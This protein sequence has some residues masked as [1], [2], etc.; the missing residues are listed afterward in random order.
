[1]LAASWALAKRPRP[2][3]A[4]LVRVLIVAGLI[5]A[6]YVG[7]VASEWSDARAQVALVHGATGRLLGGP[8]ALIDNLLS[9][10]ERYTALLGQPGLGP[11]LFAVALPA[12]A[13]WSVAAFRHL[14][15]IGRVSCAYLLVYLGGLWIFEATKAAIYVLPAV[16]PMIVLAGGL[17]P[18]ASGSTI[19]ALTGIIM[20]VLVA[21]GMVASVHDVRALRRLRTYGDVVEVIRSSVPR[22]QRW[23]GSM[24]W[25]RGFADG[26][27]TTLPSLDWRS[28]QAGD[29]YP[30]F[31]AEWQRFDP[32]VILD[33]PEW[34]DDSR[35]LAPERAAFI[36]TVSAQCGT[37]VRTLEDEAYGPVTVVALDRNCVAAIAR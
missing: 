16:V 13:I 34:R 15:A 21:E 5:A 2:A 10:P 31:R 26:A 18:R 4:S 23:I 35:R 8:A 28:R 6:P 20:A 25:S 7:W 3:F 9:E 14:D 32:T 12:V 36:A 19:R 24:R 27:F 22:D 37:P 1:M 33:T 29:A 17:V 11:A 30:A